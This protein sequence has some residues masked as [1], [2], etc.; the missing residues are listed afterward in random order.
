MGESASFLIDKKHLRIDRD[1]LRPQTYNTYVL[2]RGLEIFACLTGMPYLDKTI[3]QN[4]QTD[5]W[6]SGP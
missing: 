1:T 2:S 6:Q 5:E 3:S 4:V